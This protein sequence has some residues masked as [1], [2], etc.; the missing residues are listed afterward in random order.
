MKMIM[1]AKAVILPSQWYEGFPMTITE[2]FSM[3][4]PMIVGDIGNNGALVKDGV[5]GMKFRYDDA[6]DLVRTIERFEN[7]DRDALGKRAYMDYQRLY[8]AE[9]NYE[10]LK[11]I[12]D[13]A[14]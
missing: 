14:R 1:G 13:R 8:S 10:M 11:K 12:Y 5:N 4:T 6:G 7:V 3:G 9:A 2:A